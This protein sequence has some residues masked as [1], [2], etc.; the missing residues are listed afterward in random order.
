MT[1]AEL[2]QAEADAYAA[3]LPVVQAHC[4]VCH[5]Y[6]PGKAASFTKLDFTANPPRGSVEGVLGYKLREVLGATGKPATM[7]KDKPGSLSPKEKALMLAWADAWI[8]AHP[9]FSAP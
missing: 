9:E 1:L 7:P 6:A 8:R 5:R 3:A 2:E 4:V